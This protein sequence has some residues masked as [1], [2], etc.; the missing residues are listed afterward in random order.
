LLLYYSSG[1]FV[2][3]DVKLAAGC[4]VM[5]HSGQRQMIAFCRHSNTGRQSD[6]KFFWQ[7]HIRCGS[8]DRSTSSLEQFDV[9]YKTTDLSCGLFKRSL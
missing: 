3:T 7:E 8:S 4:A 6:T 2:R 5:Y 1:I 9:W